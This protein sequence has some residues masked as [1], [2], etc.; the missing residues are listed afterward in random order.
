MTKAWLLALTDENGAA[1]CRHASQGLIDEIAP[2]GNCEEAIT[3]AID[4]ATDED[5][6]Q[7]DGATYTVE[8]ETDTDAT[9]TVTRDDGEVETFSLIQEDGEW[10]LTS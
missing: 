3:A 2:D 4:P 8:E 9:V 10:K 6:A 5:R 1:A 7:I